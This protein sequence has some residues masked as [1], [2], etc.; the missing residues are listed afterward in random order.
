MGGRI[1]KTG[2]Q[3]VYYCVTKERLWKTRGDQHPKWK[4][5]TGC[6]MVRSLNIGRTDELV[7]NMLKT[8][9][10]QLRDQTPS[11]TEETGA[12][13]PVLD[14]GSGTLTDG[15]TWM[16]PE[17]IDLLSEEDRKV[18]VTT[19]VSKISAFF[20]AD[21]NTHHLT[22]EFSETLSG[23]FASRPEGQATGKDSGETPPETVWT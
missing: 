12:A 1:N 2:H 9:L 4:R 3:S 19:M 20:D 23:F 17:Q 5:G 11:E 18:V 13:N 7:W 21:R 16:S 8:V 10:Q 6:S 22:I 14:D 15:I